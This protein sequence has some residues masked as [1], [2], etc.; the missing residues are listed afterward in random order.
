MEASM[1]NPT[2][3]RPLTP[4]Y[5][6]FL[7]GRFRIERRD[8]QGCYHSLPPDTWDRQSPRRVLTYLLLAPGR[9]SLKDPLLDVLCPDDELDRAQAVLS[10]ALSLIRRRLVDEQGNP[11]LL[12]RKATPEKPLV[13]AGREIWCD[14]DEF[15]QTLMQAQ[16][17]E[18]QGG[19]ALPV[20]EQAYVLCQEEFLLEERY[21]EWC[22]EVRE[23]A[24]GDQRLCLLHLA[25]CYEQQGRSV[26][27]ERLLRAWLSSHAL[28]Q[29][30]LCRLMEV[31]AEQGRVQEALT[32]YQRTCKV[33][34]E[35]GL[36]PI[37]ATRALAARLREERHLPPLVSIDAGQT[38]PTQGTLQTAMSDTW[39]PFLLLPASTQKELVVSDSSH[40]LSETSPSL[41]LANGLLLPVPPAGDYFLAEATSEDCATWFSERLAHIM[42]F[43]TQWR[44][45]MYT[46][47]FEKQLDRELR[48]F[49]AVKAMFDPDTYFL[50]RRSAL[51]V[52][53]TLP[54]GLLG[55][56][57]QQKA[58]FIEEELLPACA[59]SITACWYLLNGREFASVER[60]LARYLP[61]LIT[62][63][64][65][66]S[67]YQ[68]RAAYLA[69]QA[70]LLL[71]FIELH[72]LHFQQRI[73]YCRE[74]VR[75]G[76]EAGN[77]P[78][79]VKALTQLGNAYYDQGMDTKML[80][81]YQEAKH[82]CTED[83]PCSLDK[84]FS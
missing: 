18:Q 31:L 48:M 63:A 11:L 30:V 10:Q 43:V 5:K 84:R 60:A 65:Q 32:W 45:R 57:Q 49:D 82:L 1:P 38:V 64:Q 62:W 54:K 66:P 74:A 69:A 22:R 73:V 16:A 79:L 41:Y 76:R 59:A 28:D 33:L 81:A 72:R 75:H 77:H 51:L 42:M 37:E 29:D 17:A 47:D 14:W 3:S 58:A 15:Q 80:Q 61:F 7:F 53:A 34:E 12:P 68:K 20:W 25:A 55:L 39:A 6:V 35:E 36:E 83:V 2:V 71:G 23:R 26:E 67:S 24:E 46:A 70:C 78:L 50:S 52:I 21:S 40:S 44:G 4:L 56:L 8:P 27:A 9:H 19:E 13:L